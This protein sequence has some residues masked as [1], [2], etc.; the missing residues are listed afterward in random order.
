MLGEL[1]SRGQGWVGAIVIALGSVACAPVD[2]GLPKPLGVFD[3]ARDEGQ[4][5]EAWKVDRS[6]VVRDALLARPGQPLDVVITLGPGQD[7]RVFVAAVEAPGPDQETAIAEGASTSFALEVAATV[8]G[9]TESN[10]Q[11]ASLDQAVP[12]LPIEPPPLALGERSTVKLRL[13]ATPVEDGP[14]AEGSS[15]DRDGPGWVAWSVEVTPPKLPDPPPNLLLISIDTL[16]ADRLSLVGYH[17]RTSPRIDQWALRRAVIFE[18]MVAAAPWTLPAHWTMMTGLDPFHHGVN[19][20]VGGI[21]RPGTPADVGRLTT[22][23]ERLRAHGYATA[24]ATG[25]AYLHPKYGLARGFDEYRYWRD[26][27]HD[28]VELATGVKVA[29]EWIADHRSRPFFFFLH[30]YAVHD[31]YRTWAYEEGLEPP[32]PPST[33]GLRVAL[34]SPPFVAA[35]GFRQVNQFELRQAAGKTPATGDDAELISTLYDRGVAFAD[36]KIG[37]LLDWLEATGL[38]NDTLVVITSDHG[39]ALDPGGRVGHID[40]TD[41][42]LLVPFLFALPGAA[43][44]GQRVTRQVRQIDMVPTVLDGLGLGSAGGFDGVSLLPLVGPS[45]RDFSNL[46]GPGSLDAW[47]Y[48]GASNRG[49]ALRRAGRLKYIRD[50]TAWPPGR[51][52]EELYDLEADP[53]ERA[54]LVESGAAGARL[55][56]LRRLAWAREETATGLY[57]HIAN[58]GEGQLEASLG[59]AMVRSIGTKTIDMPCDC[60]QWIDDGNA[61]LTVG[62][63]VAFTIRFEKVFAPGLHLRGTFFGADGSE[64]W[65]MGA[66]SAKGLGDQVETWRPEERTWRREDGTPAQIMASLERGFA[67]WWGGAEILH[68]ESPADEDSE[69]AEQLKVLGYVE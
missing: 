44:A 26:R 57:L 29:K 37:D 68:T 47:S 46:L 49:L 52:S 16:R 12:W 5:G 67:L 55:E 2:P 36:R 69:L 39:E 62:P 56:A 6:G 51:G 32:V 4:V 14:G 9:S 48:G 65:I 41:E 66:V 1:F 31:P 17:H 42:V 18:Q 25:G 13:R 30:T 63:G 19:H 34:R 23:A 27:A 61:K 8:A 43:G 58:R 28:H 21:D 7:L 20:D 59:G 3:P 22:L 35:N 64:V 50:N 38:A 53:A 10:S 11:V 60:L 33:K 24:A 45:D 40:L 15:P 54:N